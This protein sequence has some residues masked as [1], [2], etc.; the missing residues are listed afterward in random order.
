M[1]EVPA[2]TFNLKFR[3]K[4][5]Q[6]EEEEVKVRTRLH[7]QGPSGVAEKPDPESV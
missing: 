5:V 3:K 2:T 6:S 7:A 4:E 1:W